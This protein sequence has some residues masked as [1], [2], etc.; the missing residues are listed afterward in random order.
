[1]NRIDVG[2]ARELIDFSDAGANRNGQRR[3]LIDP[4]FAK[5]Q[6]DGTVAAYNMLAENRVSYIAD[7]VGMGKTYV[8]LGVM[9]LVRHLR[10]DA[11]VLV[12][13]PRENIQHKWVKELGNFVRNNWRVT[14][15][16]VRSIQGTPASR[17]TV[18]NSLAS[19]ARELTI[20]DGRDFFLRMTSF[21]LALRD[22]TSRKRYG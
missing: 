14:D 12:V 11:R 9:G 19:F 4:A 5:S 17:P 2:F 6:L 20:N 16:R 21:S 8:A 10:P 3:H 22:P 18:C 13:A 1:M 15:N 7:D